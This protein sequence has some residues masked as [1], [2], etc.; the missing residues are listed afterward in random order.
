MSKENKK[1]HADFQ[2]EYRRS[3]NFSGEHS[4]EEELKIKGDGKVKLEKDS[5][6]ISKDEKMKIADAMDKMRNKLENTEER[7]SRREE[8]E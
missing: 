1:D 5:K 8:E 7:E 2:S 4:E 3:S 6:M